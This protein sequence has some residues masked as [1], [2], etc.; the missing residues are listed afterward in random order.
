VAPRTT[1]R[2]TITTPEGLTYTDTGTTTGDGFLINNTIQKAVL[3]KEAFTSSQTTT[4]PAAPISKEQCK[5]GGYARFTDPATGQPFT[6]QGRCVQF[7]NT[8]K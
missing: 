7:V 8:G 4:T 1:Y 2:A 6:N 3:V 5:D